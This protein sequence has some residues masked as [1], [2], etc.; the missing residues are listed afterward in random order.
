MCELLVGLPDVTVLDVTD[1][2]DRLRV[3]VETRAAR[4]SCSGCG[5]PV[6]V[7]DRATVELTD[8]PCFGMAA[9]LVWSKVRW[10]CLDGCGS[11]TEHAPGIAAPRL[12][13]TDRAA[14][15][16]TVQVGR[17]GR[18]VS[19]VAAD[20]GCGW[21]AVMDAVV[22]YGQVLV[23]DPHR[24]ADVTA[25]G[26]DETLACRLGRWRRQQW[27][28]QIV[29]VGAGQL[30]DVVEGR[31]A[32]GPIGWLAGQS[33]TWRGGIRWAT[34]DLSGPYRKVF[35]TMLPNAIQVADPFHL[36]K[37]ANQ[38]LDEC[39]R[40]V[41]NETMGHRGRKTDPL[42]RA[43]RLLTKAHERLDDRGDAK[44]RGLLRAGDPKGDVQ[45]TWHAKETIRSIYQIDD[46]DLAVEFIDQLATDLVDDTMPV[47]VRA[48]GRTVARWRDQIMAWHQ[49]RVSNGPTEAVNNLVKRIK[50]VAFGITNFRNYRIRALLYAG[51][52]NWDLLSTLTP[53]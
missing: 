15:W 53:R 48:L 7:K 6:V 44:L 19:E 28:T 33:Q 30:L 22:A 21:H 11:F 40:R 47:E 24:F 51:R 25:L 18:S 36:V 14:R 37:L 35:D 13:I 34:L 3:T 20:L 29:D 26:L 38:R 17:H 2:G 32:A 1:C 10:A 43:R 42:Y 31:T 8:L 12:R 9:I 52:P 45:I 4:P 50:R 5:G 27:T 16:A 41:Q 23:D 49:A 46:C 39:R